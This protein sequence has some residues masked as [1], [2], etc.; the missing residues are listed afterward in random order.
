MPIYDNQKIDDNNICIIF[1]KIEI[2]RIIFTLPLLFSLQQRP[3][4]AKELTLLFLGWHVYTIHFEKFPALL[5]GA[6]LSKDAF[7]LVQM[8]EQLCHP[9]ILKF[10]PFFCLNRTGKNYK[11]LNPV[12]GEAILSFK[13]GKMYPLHSVSKYLSDL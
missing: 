1:Q 11:I 13:P 6:L 4:W 5:A 7:F 2:C 9:Q 3:K 12:D 10:P 8:M